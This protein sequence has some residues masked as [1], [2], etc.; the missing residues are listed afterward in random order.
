MQNR[1]LGGSEAMNEC[2]RETNKRVWWRKCANGCRGDVSSVSCDEMVFLVKS[3]SG[4]IE[5][6]GNGGGDGDGNDGGDGSS[7]SDDD[8]GDGGNIGSGYG[9]HGSGYGG[10]DNI[11]YR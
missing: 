4:G 5:G 1:F 7:G 11:E 2:E 8:G 9:R 3:D 6:G 10:D